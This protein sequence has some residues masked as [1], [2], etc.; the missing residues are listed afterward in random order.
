M[1]ETLG[2][3]L[4]EIATCGE[5]AGEL[6][7]SDPAASAQE[8]HGLV[9]S[10]RRTLAE[11]RRMVTRYR[12]VSLRTELETAATLLSAARVDAPPDLSVGEV[13]HS[14]DQDQPAAP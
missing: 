11:A 7:T 10:A 13:A 5:H 3:G 14:H 1:R 9:G 6:V 8:L 2:A 12:Q 4:E